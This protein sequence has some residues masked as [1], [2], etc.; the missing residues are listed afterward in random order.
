MKRFLSLLLCAAMLISLVPAAWAEEAGQELLVEQPVEEQVE[1]SAEE[2]YV[3]PVEEPTAPEE[4]AVTEPPVVEPTAEPEPTADPEPTAE[5]EPT[6]EPV[7]TAEPEA[8]PG[9]VL[10]CV[11]F[12]TTPAELTVFVYSAGERVLPNEDG[13]YTLAPGEYTYT[14]ECE[15]YETL[16]DVPFTVTGEAEYAEIEVV[17]TAENDGIDLYGDDVIDTEEKLRAAVE[18]TVGSIDLTSVLVGGNIVLTQDLTVPEMCSIQ[19]YGN[20][21]I[22]V[23][24][25]VTLDVYG[26]IGLLGDKS[27]IPVITVEEGGCINLLS[28]TKGT[29]THYASLGVSNFGKILNY[30][31]INFNDNFMSHTCQTYDEH[32]CAASFLG[33]DHS[34]IKLSAYVESQNVIERILASDFIYCDLAQ[35]NASSQASPIITGSMEIPAGK[36]VTLCADTWYVGEGATLTNNGTLEIA[37]NCTLYI[38]KG[39][40]YVDNGTTSVRGTLTDENKSGSEVASGTC[41]DDLT[42]SLDN[43]GT[44]TISGTGK[45]NIYNRGFPS[46]WYSIRASIKTVKIESGATSIGSCAFIECDSLT[47]IRIPDSVTSIGD[48]AFSGCSSLTSVNIPDGV[49]SIGYYA[50]SE[51]SGLMSIVIPDSVT[52]IGDWAFNGCISLTSINIPDRITSIGNYTFSGCSGLTNIVIPDSVT[53]ICVGAFS[54]CSSLTSVVIPDSITSIER[55]VFSGCSSLK[56]IVIPAGVTS[57]GNYAFR[58]CSSLTSIDMQ[59]NVVSI[60]DS[61]FNGCSG[62]TSI[63]IPDNVMSIGDSA[64][65]GCS[66]LTSIVIPDNAMS[67]GNSAFDG[68]SNLKTVNFDG[69]REQWDAIDIAEGNEAL[70]N[71]TIHFGN[72]VASGTCGA[73]L[74]WSL[75]I[76]G[77]LTISG[78]GGMDNYNNNSSPWYSVESSIKTVK[79]ESGVTSIGTYAFGGCSSLKT[80]NYA[81]TR[82]QWDAVDIAEGNEALKNAMIHFGNEVASGNCG[83]DLTWSL[84]NAGTFTISGTGGMDDYNWGFPGPW[85]NVRASVRTI[86]IESGVTSIGGY[87]FNGC[88]SLTSIVIPDS[89][90]SIGSGAFSGCSSLTSIVIPDSVTSIESNA[91]SGCSSLTKIA[92]PDNVTSIGNGV[93]DGCSSLTSIVIPN[94]VTSIGEWTFQKCSNLA[95]IVIPNSV[96]SMGAY[97]FSGCSSLTSINIPDGVTFIG[98][99]AFGGCSS[100][101]TVNYAGT[102][103]QW[104]AIDIAEGNEPLKKV[105][106]HLGNGEIFGTCGADLKWTLDN[107]GTLTISGTGKMTDYRY[108]N[109]S[110]WYDVRSSIKTVK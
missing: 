21:G 6:V 55:G 92:I 49:T 10:V 15:G 41:G 25:G 57:I 54:V 45:M 48:S 86:E 63:V 13:S 98:Y 40:S 61:A 1:Q 24:S 87:A 31:S 76:A 67:I 106:I 22:T 9:A 35:R 88:S 78:T 89:V 44:L 101:K 109:N 59:D 82:E 103:E 7:S 110:P 17:L 70:K 64:F 73:D 53:F 30:G 3:P 77:T 108:R 96:K 12:I 29:T 5:P 97:A 65:S 60:G 80:V 38:C 46:P 99:S 75:N 28:T 84:D 74:T 62:L 23:S 33:V 104:D 34:K 2:P 42:W 105:T 102:R 4:P 66:S 58:G 47:S 14:A 71:A 11:R 18:A 51:C 8:T 79:I 94:S 52:T 27:A 20:V 50:F 16:L 83:A 19:L 72:E 36:H 93:F 95:S 39:A 56:S 91:F 85:Y 43:A 81:G 68:C 107:A 90:T 37:P 26:G 69:T 100:L 32:D